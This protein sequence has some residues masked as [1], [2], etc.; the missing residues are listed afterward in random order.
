[1]GYKSLSD[2]SGRTTLIL[3]AK[4]AGANVGEY[5]KN[6]SKFLEEPPDHL[7]WH[8]SLLPANK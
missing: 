1:M 6:G 5:L 3:F 7:K 8:S 4:C 2:D